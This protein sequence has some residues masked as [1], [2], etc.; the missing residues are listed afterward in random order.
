MAGS[1][2]EREQFGRR[3]STFQAVAQRAANCYVD[4]EALRLTV[5]QAVWSLGDGR[6][7]ADEVAV[8]KY[9]VGETGHRVSYAA[10][11]LHGGIGVDIDYPLYRYYLWSKQIELSLGSSSHQLERLGSSLAEDRA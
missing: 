3:L 6:D 9:W 1:R 7:V 2:F 11:H 10:Q 8:A 4:V 5:Q